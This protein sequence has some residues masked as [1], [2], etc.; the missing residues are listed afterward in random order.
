MLEKGS[1]VGAHILSG[2]VIDPR[3]LD[4][5]LPDWRQSCPLAEVPVHSISRMERLKQLIPK[6]GAPW[7][8]EFAQGVLRDGYDWQRQR[9]T[10]HATMHTIRRVDNQSSIVMR[11]AT[12]EMWVTPGPISPENLDRYY[13]I[14]LHEA[15]S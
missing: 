11:P 12:G 13:R 7:T 9:V 14:D 5:L 15:F 6:D 2:A 10:P 8:V 3:A 1:E 4:E